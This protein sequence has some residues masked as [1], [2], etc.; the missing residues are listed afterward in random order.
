VRK[1][2]ENERVQGKERGRGMRKG[3][4]CWKKKRGKEKVS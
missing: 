2:K 3:K 4:Y 1:R